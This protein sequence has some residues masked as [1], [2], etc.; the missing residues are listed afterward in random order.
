MKTS[1][2][3]IKRGGFYIKK[4][5]KTHPR[6]DLPS[7]ATTL[8]TSQIA[9]GQKEGPKNIMDA[10]RNLVESHFR[11]RGPVVACDIVFPEPQTDAKSGTKWTPSRDR[12]LD[13]INALSQSFSTSSL[14]NRTLVSQQTRSILAS[15]MSSPIFP[16][17]KLNTLRPIQT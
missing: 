5:R 15:T 8:S 7:T 9:R 14:I 4:A 3:Q 11:R 12:E 16:I 10:G 1:S 13:S 17:S 6:G 2:R